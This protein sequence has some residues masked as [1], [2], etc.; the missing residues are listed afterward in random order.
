MYSVTRSSEIITGAVVGDQIA[1]LPGRNATFL[2]ALIWIVSPVAGLR[3][4]RAA[5]HQNSE[6]GAGR[7]CP[8]LAQ[9]G[10]WTTV[11]LDIGDHI[12]ENRPQRRGG[13]ATRA[14]SIGGP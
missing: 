2:L 12:S 14:V 8:L 13:V 6:P 1:I 7:A 5:H 11:Q 9:G 10:H 3:P 4:T